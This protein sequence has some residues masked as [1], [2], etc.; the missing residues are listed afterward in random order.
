[1]ANMS[2]PVKLT[3]ETTRRCSTVHGHDHTVVKLERQRGRSFEELNLHSIDVLIDHLHIFRWL[4]KTKQIPSTND[5]R[6][7]KLYIGIGWQCN[8]LS[9]VLDIQLRQQLINARVCLLALK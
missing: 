6:K 3:D 8:E 9:D 5:S 4:R 2:L 1:M 7:A